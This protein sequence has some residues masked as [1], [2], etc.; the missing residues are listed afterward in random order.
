MDL[1]DEMPRLE[2]E[3]VL[4]RE[5]V[6]A[7]APALSDFIHSEAIYRLLPTFL[8]EQKYDDPHQTIARMREECFETKES[9][10]LA[11]CL[12]EAPDQMIG[13]AEIYAYEPRKPKASIGGRLSQPYWG[14]G[15]A[16]EVFGLLKRYLLDEVHM[17]TITAH[18]MKGNAASAGALRKN[19]FVRLYADVWEDWGRGEPVLID[20]YVYKRRWETQGPAPEE[21][22]Q[23]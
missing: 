22:A 3:R 15:I 16:T 1:F 4:L 12:R 13:I 20:K 19:G 17:R 23:R 8:Y 10:L 18:V 6:D 14:Q 9:V 5:F 21:L 7:D 2:G 11:I